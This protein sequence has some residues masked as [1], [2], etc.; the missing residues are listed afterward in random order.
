MST[1]TGKRKAAC[2]ELDGL[3][4]QIEYLYLRSN[5]SVKM[6]REEINEAYGL[7]ARQVKLIRAL[8]IVEISHVANHL[9]SQRFVI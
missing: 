7:D 2:P 4:L 3:R 5:Y 1:K 9:L 6:I 8:F